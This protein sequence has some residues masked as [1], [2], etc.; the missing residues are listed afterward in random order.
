MANSFE[1]ESNSA[2]WNQQSMRAEHDDPSVSLQVAQATSG[3]QPAGQENQP[4]GAASEPKPVD[5]GATPAPTPAQAAA[6]PPSSSGEYIV[7]ADKT[8]HLPANTSIDNIRVEGTNLV[9]QQADGSVVVIKD[10]AIDVPTFIVGEVEFPRVAL[11][12][13]LQTSGVDVAFGAD[14]SI[15]AGQGAA[16]NPSAGGNF[17]H[18]AGGIGDG[19]DLSSLLPPTDLQFGQLDERELYPAAPNRDPL[20]ADFS[21][22]AL[23]DEGLAGGNPDNDGSSDTT[24][25]TLITGRFPATDPDGDALTYTFGQPSG[26]TSGGVPLVWTGQ[27]TAQLIGSVNGVPVITITAAGDSYTIQLLGPIDHPND[28]RP[29]SEDD[30][31]FTVPVTATDGK[32]G[33]TSANMSVTIEDD[34][35]A[36][37]GA[38]QSVLRVDEDGLASANADSGRS[39]ENDFGKQTVSHIELSTVINPGADGLGSYHFVSGALTQLAGLGLSSN[40]AAISYVVS[41]DGHTITG[42]AGGVSVFTVELTATGSLTFTLLGQ[43]DH[44]NSPGNVETNLSIDLSGLIEVSDKDGDTLT[45][46]VGSVVVSVGDDIPVAALVLREGASILVD[47]SLGQNGGPETEPAGTLGRVVVPGASLFN[48]AG[49]SVGS[50]SAGATKTFSLEIAAG[51]HTGLFLTGQSGAANE[52]LLVDNGGVIE[53]RVGGAGGTLA[54]TVSIDAATGNVV[55][56]QYESLNHPTPGASYDEALFLATGALKAVYTVTDGD[57]DIASAA[58]DL[59]GQRGVIAFEDDGPTA[60]LALAGKASIVVDESLGQNGAPE[61]EPVGTLGQVTVLGTSLFDTTGSLAGQDEEGATTAFSLEVAAG[62]HTGLF[63]T[64]QSGAANE[65]LLVD[66]GGVIE[67]RVGGAGGTLAFTVSIDPSTG[68]VTLTQYESLNHPTPGASYDEA[69][70][71]ASGILKAVYTVTDGDQDVASASVDLGGRAGVIAFEDDGPT[72]VLALAGKASIV[73]DESLGQNGAPETEPVGTLGQVTVLGT[74]LFDTTGSLAGQDEEGATTA[75]SLEVA[76]G[77]HTGLF[78]TGQSGAA[79]EILLVDNGGVIE[80]R[81]GGAGGTLAFTVSIDPSTGNVTLTQY[82]SL[83]HPTPGAS[84]DEALFL[85]SGILKAVYTVTDGD[86]DVATASV[87]LGGAAGVIAF[88][89]DGPTAVLALA[90]K[91]SIVV[92]ESLGQNAGEDETSSLGQVT[93]LGTSLFDTTGSSVGQ[94]NE[95]ATTAFSLEVAA[96][97]HTG[98]F[99][100][101]QSGAANEILLVDN[102][103]VIEGRV[104]GAGGT[105]AFT[106]SIDAATGN[107][108]LT[109]FESL[110]HPT[111]GASYDEALFLAS[112]ILKAVYTVTDGDQDVATASVDLGGA[113][114]VIAFEDDGPTAMLALAGKASIVVDESLGQNGAPETEPVGTLGQV[115][116]LG[117]SLFDTTGSSAGQ[118]EE[119]ATTAFSLEIAAGGHTGLFLTGQSGAANEILLVDNGGVIEGRVGGAGGTLAFTVSIDAA[120]GN[121][122]LTQYESLNHPTPGAS[123]DEALYLSANALKAVYT[124]TDGDQDVASASVDLGGRA[125][126]IA[127]EDDG[128][129]AA[130]SLKAGASIIVDE[131]LGQN[132]GE[133]EGGAAGLGQVTVLGTS[134]FD[135]TGSSA[136]QDEE[137]ATTAFSL[138]IAGGGQTGLY[139][140]GAVHDAA[141]EIVLV[142]NGGVIEGRVGGA[143]GVLA[144]TVSINATNGNV[145]L[146]QLQAL[147]H[148]DTTNADEALYLSSNVLKAVYTVTDGD[149]DVSTAKVDLGGAAGVIAFEDDAPTAVVGGAGIQA[150]VAEDTMATAD[151]DA[152]N[153]IPDAGQTSSSDEA[154]G[155]LGS[156]GALFNAGA[157]APLTFSLNPSTSGLPVLYSHGIQLVYNVAG[158]VLTATAGANTVFT[159]TVNTDGSWNFDLKDQLDHV[160]GSGDAGTLLRTTVGSVPSIDFSSMIV[161]TD[162]DGDK[163]TGAAPGSFTVT[164]QND[165]PVVV[166]LPPQTGTETTSYSLTGVQ[167]GHDLYKVLN[168]AN[169]KDILLSGRTGTTQDAVNT[170][171]DIGIGNGQNINGKDNNSA[172]EYLVLDFVKN[173]VATGN[174]MSTTFTATEHYSV[175]SLTFKVSQTTGP[176]T[177]SVFLR[178]FSVP[179]T[180]DNNSGSANFTDNAGVA[181]T[182]VSVNGTNWPVTVVYAADGVT[183]IGYLIQGVNA[184]D[185]IKVT[186]AA[187][188]GRL[189]IS[190][191]DGVTINTGGGGSATISGAKSFGVVISGSESTVIQPFEVRHD[192]SPL[193]NNTADPNIADDT[194]APLPSSLATRIGGLALTE[195]GHAV[196]SGTVAGFFTSQPGADE[197]TAITYQ[198]ANGTANTPFT[199]QDS[200]LTTT[201]GGIAIKLFTDPS[202]PRIL[203]GIAGNDFASGQKV[204]AAYVDDAGKLWLVQFQAIHNPVAGSTAADYDDAVSVIG[205]IHVQANVTDA[206]GD[207]ASAVSG[208]PIRLTFQD[209]GPHAINDIDTVLGADMTATG[210]VL[211]GIDIAAGDAN[212]DDGVADK[213][214]TDGGKVASVAG[215]STDSSPDA[216]HNFQV[217]GNYGSLVLNEDGSYVYTRFNSDPVVSQ[218]I[219]TY[220]I[221]DGDGDISTATLTIGVADNGTLITNLTPAAGGGDATLSEANLSDGSSSN[222]AALVQT[223]SFNVFAP[224]GIQSVQIGGTV[225]TIAQLGAASSASPIAISGNPA[226]GSLEIIGFD[227]GSGEITYRFTLTDNTLTHTNITADAT[228]GDRGTDDPVFANY[229]VTVTDA[230]NDSSSGTL[231]IR[232]LDDGPTAHADADAGIEGALIGGNVLTGIGTTGGVS[233][234]DVFGADGPTVA[235]GGVTGVAT[236]SN[237]A[238]PVTGNV[239]T[240][241]VTA[242][243]TLT[244]NG[245]G[246]YT[247]Q[248]KPNVVPAGGATDTF[249]YTITD[250]D[251]DTSTVTLT[252]NLS[253]SGITA[254]DNDA[255]VNEAGLSTG[256]D[257]ASNSEIFATGQITASSAVPIVSY[258]ITSVGGGTGSYGTLSLNP[259]TG[260]YTYTLTSRFDTSPDAD[261]ATN[262]E[263]NRDV[264]TYTATDANGNTVTGTIEV[265]II[266]DVPTAHADADAGIEGALIG[267]NVLTGIGTTG[268]VS[269]ADV[270]GADGPTV[271]GGGVTGVATGSNTASPVT[272]NVGTPIVTALGTLTLNGD[273]SYTYQAKPN[274]VPAG[275]ATDT[276]VYTITDGDGDTSTVTLTINLSDSGIT[277][278]DNDAIVNEAGLSTGSDAASNSEIF[279]TG[280][281]TASSAVPIVSYAITSVGG[282]TGSYGTLSLNPTTGAY[283]YTLTSRF[284]TSPDADNATNTEQNRDVFTYTATDA[285]GNT[286]TGTIEVDIVDDVPTARAGAAMNVL[287]TDG[288]TNGTSLLANDTQGADGATLTHVNLGSGFVAITTGTSLGG[289]V[290]SFSIS[291]IGVY[292]FKGDGTWTFDPA[293]NASSSNQSGSFTYRIT[294]GDGDTSEAA[295]V[296]TIANVNNVPTGG[297]VTAAVD[298]EGLLHGLVGGTGDDTTTASAFAT[299]TLTGSGGD[300]ALSYSFANLAGTPAVTIGQEQV[301]YSWDS[302]LN[303]LV[304]TIS[305]STIAARVGQVLFTVD[306]TPSTGAYQVSLI[307]AVL[308]ANANNAEAGDLQLALQYKVSDSDA[309]TSAGDTGTG[310]LTI[311]FDDDSPVNFTAQAMTI[312]NGANAIGSGA[313]NFYESIGA[314]GGSAVF[315]GTNGS[316]L[317]SGASAV[318]SG[319]KT[320]HLYGFGTDTLTA[321]IDL[322]GNGTDET[323]VFTVK[324]SPNAKSEPS[325]VYTVQFSRALDDGSGTTITT[326]NLSST[327]KRDYKMVDD[328]SANDQDILISASHSNG[329][330]GAVNGSNSSSSVAF[331]VDT[332]V[333]GLGD[334]LRFDFAKNVQMTGSGSNNG[335]TDGVHYNTNGFSFTVEGTAGSNVLVVAYDANDNTANS[336]ADLTNDAG[337]K[338]TITQIYKNGVLLNLASLTASG[339]GYIVPSVT[340]D[341]I[342]VYTSDGY[343]R[344]EVSHASGADFQISNVG[345]LRFDAGNPL[346]MSFNVQA[347]DADGDTSTG[348]ITLTTTPPTTTINGTA[349]HDNLV[350]GLGADTLNGLGGDDTLVGGAGADVLV[351]GAHSTLGD[352]ASYQNSA[353]GVTVDLTLVG[354]AQTST[355]DASGDKLTGIENLIGSNFDDLLTGDGNANVL[356]GLDGNDTLHG[357]GGDDMLYGGAGLNHLYGEGGKDTFVIDQ[358]A[359]SEVG[360]V[361]VIHDYSNADGDVVDLSEL[362]NV[363]LGT[364]VGTAG[365]VDYDNASG[366]L[367]V[368]VDG[369]GNNYVTVATLNPGL[370]TVN[371][372]YSED[373]HDKTGTAT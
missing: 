125:G 361:D 23:S 118:D 6:T 46:P 91:A 349:G 197:P 225:L 189:E 107:V 327:S 280:Q 68:N 86:Q 224:D 294:D 117:T 183:P 291:G 35:P 83:N 289:G 39:G 313:L 52:I 211:T 199:G 333:V 20:F 277:A 256:S 255:I 334:I 185:S 274:V 26:L 228:P 370:T 260:A 309:D 237:T 220:T 49:S 132:A 357:G 90:G 332:P 208:T 28:T 207:V 3:S 241:I 98:L 79:N 75:F 76:A 162:A 248:A 359:L 235:G 257:A 175:A 105:L 21:A 73:V 106:V 203:W 238:S 123:Y 254:S 301:T 324:L 338:D 330:Q 342:S 278:S 188:F 30:L 210:N 142:D 221:K 141:H 80:G 209:D 77:G 335:Y 213:L 42:S 32:G 7:G 55:L 288:Q 266:D 129:T 299:G 307:N 152:S 9:L 373:N 296:I 150:T 244:L 239:G 104:G 25:A 204:F 190:N 187:D 160:A 111:P 181:I 96:G 33:S 214:G 92:D 71:L 340:G 140:S 13:A 303:R 109:Q 24:N 202:D 358:S 219:F 180:E 282:G 122:T 195:I 170:S 45:P 4:A 127:F 133:A 354:V 47:E 275:G 173:G 273:G 323:T 310:T 171:N 110:N 38:G 265:D 15:S 154:S 326:S 297:S 148:P 139:L 158:G 130:L 2:S 345:Y 267:G 144:F 302:T 138:E 61:T 93:V 149:H 89:D 78:L 167:A 169:D 131:T 328:T 304:A 54:F 356:Y 120:T 126:V 365:Y 8:V 112:G 253:D 251:G 252:I 236:G 337:S 16:S 37:V 287:E 246:S 308:H 360:M 229:T 11:L 242:L 70:F 262:T 58:V 367:K 161:A 268:G 94:D 22:L 198:L 84:Y 59:G 234:A 66:N 103:G 259:T 322:D 362:L 286:V 314:D 306:V 284:D 69:L 347:T 135:T 134:L 48:T 363:A 27:G 121:V 64:G 159:L 176:G 352:T 200:G 174:N 97:G 316:T 29:G 366:A 191:Y 146:T 372:L 290:Y 364:N 368:D 36:F 321:R 74:S 43:V 355:G 177:A 51:G 279:A 346:N 65:I 184:G 164:V 272:G 56:T 336:Y 108:T 14:G 163:A 72:A 319:G 124:V 205:N 156:L 151:G 95:G 101:G 178:A 100:T 166:A 293:V 298:D 371:I 243:G 263:Q 18:P 339:G 226:Y 206:D 85:A 192:E 147:D 318:T 315:S 217:I 218:D 99:L 341:I 88:E 145:T 137:G 281:I 292:T 168:G 369:G 222:P 17:E 172:E 41:P 143:G 165:V 215:V 269:G 343:N 157:D 216:A 311:N 50:D 285:N 350:A 102:G 295:Q 196:S 114:G 12:A 270:F 186:G 231:A 271:A 115:T 10:G 116:V 31:T 250:G 276:F 233:G 331:G 305:S 325:D 62:G 245:D 317:M 113:A 119:G 60:V 320:V 232:V 312:E 351:G 227:S 249:V 223:G 230:D 348:S 329:T 194:A 82:E 179:T 212:T 344:I 128:P 81:V 57:K 153:G 155:T 258:A 264:F 87:D 300:G 67:G 63:L 19:F 1:I 53:G 247:Y 182:T 261:N 201:D 283:T 5:V 193:V 44:V 34:S 40:G 136:G 353:A 240:P